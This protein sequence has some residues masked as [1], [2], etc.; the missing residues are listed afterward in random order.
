MRLPKTVIWEAWCLHFGT[1]GTIFAPRGHLGG[2]WE[3]QEGHEGIRNQVFIDLESISGPY[4]DS[5][6]GIEAWNFDFVSG[7]FPGHF[8]ATIFG[9]KF[10]RRGLLKPGFRTEG[11]AKNNFP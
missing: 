11:I 5:L 9:A 2:P 6:L 8:F 10:G 3:K 4:F 1:L 7:V